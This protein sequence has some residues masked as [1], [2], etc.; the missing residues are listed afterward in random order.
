M[1]FIKYLI[2][3]IVPFFGIDFYQRL[4]A[5]SILENAFPSLSRAPIFES[6][7]LLWDFAINIALQKN[8][9]VSFV[10]YGVHE[11]YSIQYFAKEIQQ[12]DSVFIGLDSFEGLPES[13]G[14][15]PAGH[16][17][18]NSFI[19]SMDDSRVTFIKGWFQETDLA[20]SKLIT[21]RPNLIVHYDADLYSST[22]FALSK[23]DNF[24]L[25]PKFHLQ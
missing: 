2:R 13:W 16:F 20:L 18:T 4:L 8:T 21:G 3:K 23:I 1:K 7:E 9:P 10:E 6:R 12:K 19:P 14:A 24:D 11:G 22:L 15:L 25:P 17:S 5:C